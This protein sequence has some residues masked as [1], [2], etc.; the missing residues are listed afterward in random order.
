MTNLA[1]WGLLLTLAVSVFFWK[2]LFTN[3]FSVLDD[4][5]SANQAYSW[6]QFAVSSIQSG[7]LPLWDPSTWSGHSF[8]GEMQTGLFYPLKVLLYF[9]PLGKSG[10]LSQRFFELFYVLAHLLAAGFL[11]LLAREIGIENQ[12][13]AF[14]AAICFALGGF[15]GK[16][17]WPNMLDSAIWLPLIFLFLIRAFRCPSRAWGL[18][19]ACLSGLCL[20]M[21]IL[22]GSLHVPVSQVLAL[23]SAAVFLTF[24]SEE[25]RVERPM[26]SRRLWWSGAVV[27]TVG[28]T[29]FASGAVQLLPSIEY[30][31]LSLE[32]VGEWVSPTGARMSYPVVSDTYALL[33]RSLYGF[34]FGSTFIGTAEFSPYLGVLPLLLTMIGIWKNWDLP[35]VKFLT[36]MGVAA[37][38]YSLGPYSLFHGLLY[39]LVPVLDHLRESGRFIYLTHFAMAL[40]AGFG[41]Q[42]LFSTQAGADHNLARALRI[43]GWAVLAISAAL[44]IPVIYGKPDII[45]W[46]FMTVLFLIA[47][48]AILLSVFRG[49]R[50]RTA[51]LLIAGLILWDLHV[52]DWTVKSEYDVRA[53]HTNQL[54]QLLALHDL[55]DFV[56]SQPGLF[57]VHIKGGYPPNIGD[58]FGVAST[59]GTAKTFL[60]DYIPYLQTRQAWNLLNVRYILSATEENE[61]PPVYASGPWKLYQNSFYCP[62]A[63]VVYHVAPLARTDIR[64]QLSDPAFHPLEVAL[65]DG[66]IEAD[67]GESPANPAQVNFDLYQAAHLEL[68][69]Q[70]TATGL[71]VLSEVYYPGWEASVNGKPIRIHK[72]DGLLRGVVVPSGESRVTFRYRPRSILWGA[73]LTIFAFT[74][75]LVFAGVLR[76]GR[77]RPLGR[78]A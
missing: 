9:W 49:N 60:A 64:R 37:F 11:F 5:E 35:W 63:W 19:Y 59:V 47:S 62:R 70:S 23:L 1:K 41:V 58:L 54:E 38:I 78:D 14:I 34:L 55:A 10:L 7:K 29:A 56:K 6:H 22:A 43:L 27:L 51:Q 68:R 32:W 13:A 39:L 8:V 21:A 73:V 50:T 31:R 4:S 48:W 12:F 71:L 18:L 25:K 26:L 24:Q 69:V 28:V 45:E 67:M 74:G 42:T 53:Q 44:G 66:P 46:D 57:R 2:I 3:D 15:V 20:G 30:S 36:W 77:G 72:V 17:G 65:I 33:P 52:F 16:M 76:Y 40:L 61:G 75:T